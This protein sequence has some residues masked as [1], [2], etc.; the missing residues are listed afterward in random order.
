MRVRFVRQIIIGNGLVVIR[1]SDVPQFSVLLSG[2]AVAVA[3]VSHERIA[4]VRSRFPEEFIEDA[5]G[6]LESGF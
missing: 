2:P 4:R 6:G 5:D 1:K 3:L